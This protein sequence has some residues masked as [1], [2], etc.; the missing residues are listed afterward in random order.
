MKRISM[1]LAIVLCVCSFSTYAKAQELSGEQSK[2]QNNDTIESTDETVSAF[3]ED[4]VIVGDSIAMGLA[5]YTAKNKDSV[6]HNMKYL[7]SGGF[8]YLNALKEISEDSIHPEYKG[9]QQY[10]WDSI[11]QMKVKKVF[12]SLGMNDLNPCRNRTTAKMQEVIS[13]ILEESPK[14][15]IYI[16]SITPV[17]KGAEVGRI[18]NDFIKETNAEIQKLAEDNGLEYIDVSSGLFNEEGTLKEE[19]CSDGFVHL[20]QNAYEEVYEEVFTSLAKRDSVTNEQ[21]SEE[22]ED[23]TEQSLTSEVSQ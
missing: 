1:F 4:S 12:L 2:A 7:T 23:E 20:S 19:Y 14:V 3:F 18:N 15:K 10:V 6:I 16:L 8:G 11:K 21:P 17:L 5:K 22:F 9:K 13:H